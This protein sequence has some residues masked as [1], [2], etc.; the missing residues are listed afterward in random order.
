[1]ALFGMLSEEHNQPYDLFAGV[2]L[3]IWGELV[4][5]ARRVVR[6]QRCA[7][8]TEEESL[9]APRSLLRRPA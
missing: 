4:L 7:A 1:M 9:T 6:V 3:G 5:K 2:V 8:I